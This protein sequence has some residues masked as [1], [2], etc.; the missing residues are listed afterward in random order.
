MEHDPPILL[1]IGHSNHTLEDFIQLLKQH[2]VSAVADV[3]S[4]PYSRRLDH[5]NR[6]PLAAELQAAAIRYVFL[7]QELGARR[8]EADSYTG[9]QATYE[10]VATL[11]EFQQGL[12]RLRHGARQYRIVLMC[13]EKE[14]LDCHRTIL[15]CRQLRSEFRIQHILADGG[16][17]EHQQT[18]R[19]LVRQMGVTRTL[20][21][22]HL[23]EEDLIQQA[24]QQRG[25]Q[26][27][28]RAENE[29]GGEA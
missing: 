5:F 28:Y 13:A 9:N 10:R 12:Q 23:T 22:P 21:E 27:A 25:Q 15:I 7:G 3:R 6:E 20:F 11:P 17:E 1:T 2:R 19:R 4:H 18:E 14:P 8:E 29:E 26:I 16:L 24:Y